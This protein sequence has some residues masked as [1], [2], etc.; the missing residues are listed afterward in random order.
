MSVY[1]RGACWAAIS[2]ALLGIGYL[3]LNTSEIRAPAIQEGVETARQFEAVEA[4]QVASEDSPVNPE[5][6]ELG[7]LIRTLIPEDPIVS[8]GEHIRPHER[9]YTFLSNEDIA[10]GLV[11]VWYGVWWLTLDL[12]EERKDLVYTV[13][14]GHATRLF[15]MAELPFEE[16]AV[17]MMRH[18][19]EL[20]DT[21]R[22]ALKPEQF[23]DWQAL[24]E[25]KEARIIPMLL[26]EFLLDDL[27]E[28][29]GFRARVS[30]V[31][32]EE[33]FAHADAEAWLYDYRFD[34]FEDE[35]RDS[36][37]QV[38]LRSAYRLSNELDAAS[39]EQVADIIRPFLRQ[40]VELDGDSILP[41][42][43]P[44]PVVEGFRLLYRNGAATSEGGIE[45]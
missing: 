42:F 43:S 33:A 2:L 13:L 21:L 4:E 10:K 17:E 36:V 7:A 30:E 16:F 20:T 39:F 27:D 12:E 3:Y 19:K 35:W 44:A 8:E 15:E 18:D 40:E 9:T 14:H 26:E 5:R 32:V 34:E 23:S 24:E 31:I 41:D 11:T 45:E 6:E 29:T 28:T 25:T 22:S 37:R 1:I 38:G